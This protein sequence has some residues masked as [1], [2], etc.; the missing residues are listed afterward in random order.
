V[1]DHCLRSAGG[2]WFENYVEFEEM[3]RRLLEDRPLAQA[4]GRGG[5]AYVEKE[6]SWPSVLGRFHDALR[7]WGL[8]AGAHATQPGG[9][10][11]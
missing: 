2:L 11:A 9:A 5:R 3:L 10:D 7:S 8:P 1:R 6:Y 4:L